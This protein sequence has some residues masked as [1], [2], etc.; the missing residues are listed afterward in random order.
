MGTAAR[1]PT[2]G[3]TT[4]R[5]GSAR[6]RANH[7]RQ[8]RNFGRPWKPIARARA[9]ATFRDKNTAFGTIP[10]LVFL[11]LPSDGLRAPIA[12]EMRAADGGWRLHVSERSPRALQPL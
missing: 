12:I 6:S 10:P 11:A 7:R 9:P 8:F 4:T 3:S 5:R 2:S 1:K